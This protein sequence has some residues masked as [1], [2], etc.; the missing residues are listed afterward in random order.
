M[1]QYSSYTP[2]L[3]GSPVLAC[4]R[5]LLDLPGCSGGILLFS[6]GNYSHPQCGLM[7]CGAR[8]SPNIDSGDHIYRI[9]SVLQFSHIQQ[10]NHLASWADRLWWD[11]SSSEWGLL[12]GPAYHAVE[13]LQSSYLPSPS[14]SLSSSLTWIS[15]IKQL[16]LIFECLSFLYACKKN[17]HIYLMRDYKPFHGEYWEIKNFFQVVTTINT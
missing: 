11:H 8:S 15:S 12:C 2:W 1:W 5:Y 9:T 10:G 3:P 4:V 16:C 13:C 17:L 14:T 6:A 7:I